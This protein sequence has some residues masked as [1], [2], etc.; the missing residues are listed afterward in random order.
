MNKINDVTRSNMIMISQPFGNT[1][2]IFSVKLNFNNI[3][4]INTYFR[5]LYFMMKSPELLMTN[6]Y[7][8]HNEIIMRELDIYNEEEIEFNKIS[9]SNFI[10]SNNKYISITISI[11]FKES[12]F[13]ERLFIAKNKLKKMSKLIVSSNG[14]GLEK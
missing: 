13:K 1:G 8:I 5:H 12:N 2:N 7:V 14:W 10:N 6:E 3:N 4:N 11:S 9:L